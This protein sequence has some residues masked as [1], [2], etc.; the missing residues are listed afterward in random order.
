MATAKA[1]QHRL[2]QAPFLAGMFDSQ[3]SQFVGFLHGDLLAGGCPCSGIGHLH[4]GS[5]PVGE[6]CDN[7]GD[8]ASVQRPQ[9]G[10]DGG[11]GLTA[12]GGQTGV[13]QVPLGRVDRDDGPAR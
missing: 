1:R 13:L 2:P 12:L 7:S 5:A 6:P 9:S 3:A 4:Q 10:I 11:Q 8:A